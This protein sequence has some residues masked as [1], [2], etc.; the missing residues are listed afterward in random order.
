MGAGF[1]GIEI[2][3]ADTTVQESPIAYPTEVGHLK[4]IAEKILGFGKKLRLGSIE[5]LVNLK[6]MAQ[7]LFTSIRLFTRGKTEQ[8]LSKKKKLSKKLHSKVQKMVRLAKTNLLT[9]RGA[10]AI[11]ARKQ[12]DLYE[13]MLGQIKVG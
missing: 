6:D 13:H 11:R 4:N 2:C 10:L 9:N 12:L 3:A 1:T 7:G 5:T 8:A